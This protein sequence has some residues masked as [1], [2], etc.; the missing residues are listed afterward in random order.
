MEKK[1]NS[2]L[3]N[4]FMFKSLGK[5]EQDYLHFRNFQKDS[6]LAKKIDEI[7]HTTDN[8]KE[9]E[10]KVSL[11]LSKEIAEIQAK[12]GTG[13]EKTDPSKDIASLIKAATEEKQQETKNENP[14]NAEGRVDGKEKADK[15]SHLTEASRKNLKTLLKNFAI[16]E[17]YKVMNP[18]RIAGETAKT[19]YMHNMAVGGEKLASKHTGGKPRDLAKYSAKDLQTANRVAGTFKKPEGWVLKK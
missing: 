6:S 9:I 18:R 16:Y 5:N 15:Y 2:D 4:S 12:R 14:I 7:F 8:L 13:S 19:N 10:S 17:V 3:Q 1:D 11:L